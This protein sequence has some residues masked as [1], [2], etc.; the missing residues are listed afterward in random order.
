[1][2]VAT[3][4]NRET[5]LFWLLSRPFTLVARVGEGA[6]DHSH[7][8]IKGLMSPVDTLEA[9]GP[10]IGRHYQPQQG[11]FVV[12]VTFTTFHACCSGGGR[13]P[14]SQRRVDQGSYTTTEHGGSK[15]VEEW[16]SLLA[17][18]E[19]LGCLVTFTTYQAR[20]LGWGRRPRSQ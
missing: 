7:E 14:R 13:R 2:D 12:L 16:T 17:T 11:K 5:L 1:M 19:K 3:S 9:G 15:R 20:C 18:I 6:R 10:K 4:H 8:L